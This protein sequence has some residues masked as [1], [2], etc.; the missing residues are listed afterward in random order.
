MYNQLI[1][2]S[3]NAAL[4]DSNGELM[5]FGVTV[6][7]R[8]ELAHSKYNSALI[9]GKTEHD[10]SDIDDS[11]PGRLTSLA[12]GWTLVLD[13]NANLKNLYCYATG[14]YIRPA[15]DEEIAA[16]DEAEKTNASAVIAAE[17]D[18]VELA[19]YVM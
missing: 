3:T 11:V 15:T 1:T 16:A 13:G 4:Y 12:A 19:C 9:V 6:Q 2:L 5:A 8:I 17:V 7:K 18:G 14:A 10:L